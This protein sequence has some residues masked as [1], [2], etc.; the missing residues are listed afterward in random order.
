ML[1]ARWPLLVPMCL[2]A[3]AVS[4]TPARGGGRI[5]FTNDECSAGTRP[6]QAKPEWRPELRKV[7]FFEKLDCRALSHFAES[8]RHVVNQQTLGA[9]MRPLS[10]LGLTSAPA[11]AAT[12]PEPSTTITPPPPPP[13]TTAPPSPSPSVPAPATSPEPI[14]DAPKTPVAP[15]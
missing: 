12:S 9:Y 14:P 4:S 5:W 2:A 10:S 1:T 15:K 6:H 8:Q 11:P 7:N 13:T 3:M